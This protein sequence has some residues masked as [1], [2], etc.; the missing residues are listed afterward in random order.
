MGVDINSGGTGTGFFPSTMDKIM[1]VFARG[2]ICS[3]PFGIGSAVVLI[4]SVYT[5]P[6]RNRT[7]QFHMGSPL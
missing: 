6:V 2:R 5:G 7:V 3:D 1:A 4:H